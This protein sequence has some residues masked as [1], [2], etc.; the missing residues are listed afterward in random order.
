MEV[1]DTEGYGS[2]YERVV[3]VSDLNT[4]PVADFSINPTSGLVG[5]TITF[6][7]TLCSDKEDSLDLLEVRWDW[8]NDNIYETLW[9]STKVYTNTY[10]EAGTYIIKVQVRDREGLTDTRVKSIVIK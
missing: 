7:A 2:T 3:S 6:D 4:P 8:N 10:A 1:I 9:S 5:Q